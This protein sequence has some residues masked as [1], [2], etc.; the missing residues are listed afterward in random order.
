MIKDLPNDRQTADERFRRQGDLEEEVIL[1]ALRD[2]SPEHGFGI[3]LRTRLL[4][5]GAA[6]ILKPLDQF[7]ALILKHGGHLVSIQPGGADPVR[8]REL[9]VVDLIHKGQRGRWLDARLAALSVVPSAHVEAVT[10]ALGAVVDAM[11][12]A[13]RHDPSASAADRPIPKVRMFEIVA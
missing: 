5:R 6:G 9:V 13:L 12:A 4:A 11:A 1:P 7:L 10:V 2:W 8:F 3:G